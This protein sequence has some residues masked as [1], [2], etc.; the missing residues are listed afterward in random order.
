MKGLGQIWGG[1]RIGIELGW[2]PWAE[3]EG[4]MEHKREE[5]RLRLW[6]QRRACVHKGAKEP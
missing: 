4:S 1:N 6:V 3:G 2:E 5:Q